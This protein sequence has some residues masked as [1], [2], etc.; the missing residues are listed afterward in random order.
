MPPDC[1][2][3]Q[4]VALLL[5]EVASSAINVILLTA[6]PSCADTPITP[7]CAVPSSPLELGPLTLAL[8]FPFIQSIIL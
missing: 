7:V 2:T 8:I 3:S 5:A 4:P 6:E 1:P